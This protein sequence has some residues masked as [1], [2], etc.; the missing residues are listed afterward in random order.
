MDQKKLRPPVVVVV[1][2]VDHGKT[3]LL[4]AIRKTAV[5]K[6]EAGG[7]TQSIGASTINGITF[8][9]TPGH[10]LFA[11]MR[12]RGVTLA[13]IGILVVAT[14][15]GVQ[16]QTKEALQLLQ[17]SGLPFVVALTKIDLATSNTE[18]TLQQL[19]KEGL[20]FEKRGGDTAYVGISSKTG[21]GIPQLL[22]LIKLIA[23]VNEIN[24]EANDVLDG[25][26]IETLKDKRG[27]MVSVVI[28]KGNV[29]VGD[30]I[31]ANELQAK[32]K[33][34]FDNDQKSV[35]EILP[36][37]AG[38]ILGFDETPEVG[39]VISS[40]ATQ[41]QNKILETKENKNAKVKIFVKAK[42]VG[43]LE[44]LIANIPEDVQVV[45]SGV[46]DV[47]ESDIF[48]A[49]AAGALIF[50]FE[51]K[52]ASNIRKL[53]EMETVK[54]ERFDVVYDLLE[55]LKELALKDKEEISGK[56]QILAVFPFNAKKIAGSKIIQGKFI[57][58]QSAKLMRNET[59]IG[60]V[61][62]ISIRKQKDEINEA[63][64]G[65]E[66]GILFA[67]QLDFQV[68]DVLLSVTK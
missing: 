14:D 21:E 46:G 17:Q 6:R 56:A 52:F 20:Y 24:G 64:Q 55:K 34:I 25:F 50:L 16:P 58:N 18:T 60:K 32:V 41:S 43:S 13:D 5:T 26:V 1:G 68:G 48:Y 31:F 23:E 4:D 8:I 12:S 30:S 35:K 11:N 44:A 33:G 57:K 47:I 59:E 40:I 49:K 19:E 15:D 65:Q 37:F 29:K 51:A 66:C 45:G 27:T 38:Q 36:G 3:S 39:S 63:I 42:T 28:K 9:D 54:M 10:A 22:D 61:R 53:A 7:I 62:I 2:H 67:P